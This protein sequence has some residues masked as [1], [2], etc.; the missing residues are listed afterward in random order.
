MAPATKKCNF[1]VFGANA[2]KQDI[3]KLK[4]CNSKVKGCFFQWHWE[5]LAWFCSKDQWIRCETKVA[6][7]LLFPLPFPPLTLLLLPSC[8]PS[9]FLSF[10]TLLLALLL[11]FSP[12]SLRP[13]IVGVCFKVSGWMS[14]REGCS[15]WSRGS[16]G[17]SPL[18]SRGSWLGGSLVSALSFYCFPHP[19]KRPNCGGFVCFVFVW[20]CVNM[21]QK[22]SFC[23]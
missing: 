4:C 21:A 18:W 6:C 3:S 5:L 16:L 2:W 9:F 13:G 17:G 1:K 23:M 11:A 12:L 8:F 14:C 15:L 20:A 22:M 7:L 10:L 19:L